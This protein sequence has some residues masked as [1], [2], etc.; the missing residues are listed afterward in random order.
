MPRNIKISVMLIIF[1]MVTVLFLFVSKLTTPR[2][3]SSGELLVNGFYKFQE[4][5]QFSDFSIMT[6][7][8]QELTKQ[9]FAGKWTLIYF[10][11]TRC[12]AEC[13]VAMS[14]MKSL[15]A[16]LDGKNLNLADKQVFLITIDPENDTADAVDSYAKAFNT[17]FMGARGDR[18]TLL[19]MATQFNVMV[20]EPPKAMDHD[21]M[22]H[23]EN[24]SNN[25]LLVNP[26]GEY[27]GFFRSPFDEE[28]LLLT[29]QSV[30]TSR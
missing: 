30:V 25:I 27:V 23:L 21:H 12:P 13:P 2:Y 14:L 26:M 7:G 19:S 17:S 9:D 18:A 28:N 11:Y 24:H 1:F 5:K 22:G 4:P 10:G 29:Y 16:T 6:S 3:L 8:S 20:V 15:Y